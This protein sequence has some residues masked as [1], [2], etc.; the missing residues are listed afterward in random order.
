MAQI[1][2]RQFSTRADIKHLPLHVQKKKF[3][4][5]YGFNQP[6]VMLDVH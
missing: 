1:G 4:I 6:L 5:A 2:W 3:L